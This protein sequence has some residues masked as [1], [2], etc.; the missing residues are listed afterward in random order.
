MVLADCRFGF[1]DFQGAGIPLTC[2]WAASPKPKLPLS[3]LCS[4]VQ[5]RLQRL[6]WVGSSTSCLAL[7]SLFLHG[8]CVSEVLC[9]LN[10]FFLCGIQGSTVSP[11]SSLP[12]YS[13]GINSCRASSAFTLTRTIYRANIYFVKTISPM[14]NLTFLLPVKYFHS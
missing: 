11:A 5:H 14:E 9:T 2:L 10:F 4:K 12:G 8:D 13:T 1:T 3:K 7:R 6:K